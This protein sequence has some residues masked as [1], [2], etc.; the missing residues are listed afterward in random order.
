MK[1]WKI[2]VLNLG[3]LIWDKGWSTDGCDLNLQIPVPFLAFL[4]DNGS[5]K[6]LVDC[7]IHE[8]YIK[9]GKGYAGLKTEGG[10][11]YILKALEAIAVK[12]SDVE[13]VLYTHL[14]NDHVGGCHLFPDSV[15]VFQED[16]WKGLCTPNPRDW[17]I[18]GYDFD[19]IPLFRQLQCI[20]LEGDLE[21][22]PGIKLYKTPGHSN[23]GQCVAV[24]TAKGTYV[25]TGDTAFFKCTLYP[26]MDRMTLMD[27]QEI[28]ITP[29]ADAYAPAIP[30]G[31][32]GLIRDY[33]AW[34]RSIHRMKL[35]IKGPEFALTGHEPS[36]VLFRV[37]G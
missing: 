24:D 34:Y 1:N 21:I 5:K 11:Q 26:K 12:P 13:M 18:K 9:D 28:K 33:D 7:G 37:F 15:H 19:I 27:G 36:L 23:G 31:R 16:E 2:H 32:P 6:I 14:H 4:L 22:E 10:S 30:F 20:R 3:N 17:F 29:Y 8:K 35:L 25:M